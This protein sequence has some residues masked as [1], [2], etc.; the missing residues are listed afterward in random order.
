VICVPKSISILIVAGL[1]VV[2]GGCTLTPESK[3]GGMIASPVSFDALPGWAGDDHGAA[4]VA[5]RRSCDKPRESRGP[6]K[7]SRADWR[8]PCAA[9]RNVG[10]G[11]DA[12]EFFER[13]FRPFRIS[14]STRDSGLITGYFEADLRGARRPSAQFNVPI[15]RLPEDLVRLDLRHFDTKL[16]KKHYVGR[17]V[18][19]ELRPYYE[20]GDIADG[21]LSDKGQEL[22]WVDDAIDAFVLH[23]QGSGRVTM[24][25]GSVVRIGYAGNNGWPYRS[26]GRALIARGALQRGGASWG[27]IRRWMDANPERVKALL[28]VNRRYIFFR[29]I[30]GDGPIGAAGVALTPGRSLA[31]DPRY[32]PFGVPVWLD[33]VWPGSSVKPLRRLMIAQD[34]GNAIRGVV[35]GDFFWGFGAPALAFAGTM[36]SQGRYFV[37]LPKAAAARRAGS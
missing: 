9:A 20:R 27:D 25:D 35:R 1:A 16:A 11:D 22:L 33:T 7:I 34:S 13:W 30:D 29:V 23:V 15:Y 24:R 36:K 32:M 21:A 19:G 31:V 3:P 5:L 28:A 17:V 4:L 18:G 10:D 26:I 12:R 37:L 8:A 6:L 2:L 14:S